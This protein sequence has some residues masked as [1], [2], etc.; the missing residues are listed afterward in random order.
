[1][2]SNRAHDQ[3]ILG[4][5]ALLMM[6]Y[7]GAILKHNNKVFGYYQGCHGTIAPVGSHY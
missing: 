1:M 3:S 4:F 7:I 6:L 2:F 5:S